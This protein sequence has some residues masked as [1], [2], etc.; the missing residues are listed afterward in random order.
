MD[1]LNATTNITITASGSALAFHELA[2]HAHAGHTA[3]A[4]HAGHA[5]AWGIPR[6][7]FK[8]HC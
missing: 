1:S 4:G 8:R 5:H 2:A 7:L 6:T 3:H